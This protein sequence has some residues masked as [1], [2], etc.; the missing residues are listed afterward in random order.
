MTL[1]YIN[2]L[3]IPEIWFRVIQS[4][5]CIRF[6]STPVT[7]SS[8]SW[9]WWCCPEREIKNTTTMHILELFF[10]IRIWNINFCLRNILRLFCKFLNKYHQNHLFFLF[11]N[12][13]CKDNITK[14]YD[15]YAKTILQNIMLKMQRRQI[16]NSTYVQQCSTNN[17]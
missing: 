17:S 4:L 1:T 14:Y 8:T 10:S 13:Y 12:L 3:N 2:M 16:Y 9:L 7:L 15:H 11:L 5:V 6:S